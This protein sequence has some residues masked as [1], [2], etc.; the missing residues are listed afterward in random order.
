MLG[1]SD[2]SEDFIGGLGAANLEY[3]GNHTLMGHDNK[4]NEDEF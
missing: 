4:N 2:D 1:D 3:D